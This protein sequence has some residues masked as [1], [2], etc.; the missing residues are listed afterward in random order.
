M[1]MIS[2]QQVF[3]EHDHVSA[4]FFGRQGGVSEGIY[5]SLNCG[6][7]SGDDPAAVA[8]NR[9]RVAAELGVGDV[10]SLYQVH[11]ADCLRVDA[12]W[13]NDEARPKADAFVT[14]QRGV[15]LGILTADCAPVLFYADSSSG[16]VVGAAHAGWRGALG[17]VLSATVE[18]MRG[19]DGVSDIHAVVGPC[20]AQASYE[21]SMDFVAP[22]IDASPTYEHFFAA[23]PQDG[24]LLFDLSGFCAARLAEAG[25]RHVSLADIDTYK[26]AEAYF[27]YRRATHVGEADY[28]R[29]LS[30]IALR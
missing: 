24:K 26:N 27:S 7:G 5:A 14:D 3:N 21:V 15:G 19:Y 20:I 2:N 13:A 1:V 28:G 10:L 30:V 8:E 6:L 23:A 4:A 17:G 25:V 22:F 9:A 16:G 11:G 18:A 12:G 29:Q